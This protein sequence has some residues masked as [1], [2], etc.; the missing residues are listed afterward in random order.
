[1]CDHPR[2]VPRPDRLRRALPAV[3]AA[4]LVLSGEA[5]SA[6]MAA[7]SRPVAREARIDRVRDITRPPH[8]HFY[9]APPP[10][11]VRVFPGTGSCYG[12]PYCG[13]PYSYAV[14]YV[15]PPY[16]VPYEPGRHRWG[17]GRHKAGAVRC[18][19]ERAA[20]TGCHRLR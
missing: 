19:A 4:L 10:P 12:G 8:I 14:P 16:Y 11:S 1:M 17:L 15:E 20:R 18:T 3:A 2:A 9:T 6:P 5:A 13:V 7:G